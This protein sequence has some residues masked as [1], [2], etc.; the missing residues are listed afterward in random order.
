MGLRVGLVGYGLAGRVFHAP[1]I[2]STPGL[3]LAAIV[4]SSAQRRASASAAHPTALLVSTVDELLALKPDLVVVATPND[5]HV[6]VALAAVAAGAAVVVD[7]PFA[8]TV[9]EATRVV[10]AA[11]ARSVPLTVFQN[12]RWDSD[13]L[14]LRS[15]LDAGALGTVARF[16]SRFERWSPDVVE[17][18]RESPGGGVL[19]DL[20]SHLVDQAVELFGPVRSAY[21][22]VAA[23]RAS[24]VA[25]DD[26]FVSLTHVGGVRSHLW[27]SACAAHHGPRFR[28]LGSKSAYVSYGL[29]GQEEA[30]SRGERCDDLSTPGLLGVL[31]NAVPVS[32]VPGA[33]GEFYRLVEASLTSGGPLPVDVGSAVYTLGVLEAAVT[34]GATGRVVEL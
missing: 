2:A 18:W 9:A 30:L 16:E 34:S 20:G 14:T 3:T 13:F 1:L 12:R 24:A 10:E 22:E 29:D 5:T 19:H 7:K 23:R 4:T 31:S 15:L 25:D 8:G 11:R 28:V 17:G 33:Y 6:P 27:A 32:G 26:V 21:A